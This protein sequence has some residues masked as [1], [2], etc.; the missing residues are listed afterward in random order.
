LARLEQSPGAVIAADA[1]GLIRYT[2][3][4]T[5][6]LFGYPTGSLIGTSI[7]PLLARQASGT[8]AF[9]WSELVAEAGDRPILALDDLIGRRTNGTE[10]P[11]AMSLSGIPTNVGTLF[12]AGLQDLTARKQVEARLATSEARFDTVLDANPNTVLSIDRSG[13]VVYANLAI[14]RNFGYTPQEVIGQPVDML[15]PDGARERHVVHRERYMDNP[16]SR[17]MGIGMDLAGRRKDGTEFPAEISLSPLQTAEG[18]EVFARIVDI[19]ARKRAEGELLQAR[20]LESVG[21]LAGGIAHD[22]NNILFAIGGYAELLAQDLSAD[23]PIDRESAARSTA[24]IGQAVERGR[25]LTAQ[26]LAFSRRQIVAPRVVDL[27]EAVRGVEPILRRLI[28][29]N[30]RLTLRLGGTRRLKA[31]PSQLDQILINLAVN[32]RDAMPEGGTLEIAT[33]E[34][35][36]DARDARQHPEMVPGRYVYLAVSDTG[37]GM[38]AETREHIFEP[39]FTTKERG[40]GT[41]LGLATIYGIV[42]QSGGHIWA[43]SEPGKGSVFKLYF[44]LVDEAT[45][46]DRPA[47]PSASRAVSGTVLVVEDDEQVRV[48]TTQLLERAGYDVLAAEHAARALE[49]IEGREG[50]AAVV[51]DVIMPGM[52]GIELAEAILGRDPDVGIVLLSGYTEETLGLDRLTARH[53]EF[54]SKPI[55][56]TELLRAIE[57]AGGRSRGDQHER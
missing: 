48:M 56:G 11:V 38:D 15:L 39:F 29:E 36:F 42:G 1:D 41:G 19:S 53:V 25:E 13:R 40:K 2:N 6:A 30:V 35:E 32:A 28:G 7:E 47:Q 33:G 51:S 52:S 12:F 14:E 45:T 44:P 46:E 5:E 55:S 57:R 10:F 34:A 22:F 27:D 4:A 49:L 21:R 37:V 24:A 18:F 8:T 20:K 9:R 54:V 31:D 26:L 16:V 23:G 3:P 50:I 17:P 43:Y